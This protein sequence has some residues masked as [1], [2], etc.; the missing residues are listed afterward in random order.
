MLL[1]I[2]R[3]G[4]VGG[5]VMIVF[6]GLNWLFGHWWG[7]DASFLLAYPPSLALHFILNKT[8]TFGC[9]RTDTGRQISEYAAMALVTFLI[10]VAVFK[11]LTAFTTM[12]GWAA[13]AAANAAQVAITFFVMQY[14]IFRPEQG[15]GI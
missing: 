4:A 1:R 13:A 12:P 6:A 11:L 5:V 10:Q 14:R 15:P 3:F 2:L 8:W 7:K 9:A